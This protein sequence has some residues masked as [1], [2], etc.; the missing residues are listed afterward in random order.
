M[1]RLSFFAAFVA[2]FFAAAIAAAASVP[3][4]VNFANTQAV[5]DM[6]GALKSYHAPSG[7]EADG[8]QWYMTAIVNDSVRPATR[9][10]LAGEPP[11]TALKFFPLATRPEIEQVASSDS[12]VVVEQARAYGHRAYRVTVPPATS[13]SLA[14]RV[15]HATAPPSLLAWTE[16]ALIE[17]NRQIA[18]FIAAVAGLIGASAA[19]MLGLWAMTSHA[20]PRWAAFTLIAL[21]LAR[22][23]TTGMFDAAWIGAF[24]GPYG[25]TAFFSGLALAAGI[26]LADVVTPISGLWLS[27]DR[28]LRWLLLGI[29]ALS[30]LALVGIPGMTIFVDCLVVVGAA[31]IATY[32]VHRGRLGAQAARVLAPTAAVFALVA[33][34]AAYVTLG[35]I[36]DNIMAPA[37]IGGFAA[38]GAVLLALA[39]AAG[40]GIA[41]T[42]PF[43]AR[44]AGIASQT[45]ARASVSSAKSIAQPADNSP[46]ARAALQAIGASHQGVF[47]FDFRSALVRLSPEAA[48]LIGMKSGA[49]DIAQDNWIARIH[50]DDREIYKQA[51]A[52]Y[53]THPGLAFRIEFRVR[54]ESGRYPWFELRATMIGEGATASRCLG[55]MADVT[56]RKESEAAVADRSTR[57]PL[58]GLGNR[59]ALMEALEQLGDRLENAVF[60]VL[61]IDRFKAIHASLGDAGADAVLA[62]I[63]QRL[64]KRFGALAEAFRVGG[65]A[66][67]VLF[68]RSEGG[69]EAIGS[70]LADICTQP[71]PSAGRNV[72]AR[73]SV[74]VAGGGGARDPLDLVKNAELALVQ[75]KRHGGGCA[76]VYST[77]LETT[78]A[79]DP[80]ALETELRRALAEQQLDIFYQPIVRLADGTVAG[81]EALLRWHHPSRGLV[82]PNEFIAHSEQTGLIVALGKFALDRAVRDLAQWQRYF[83]LSP[84]LFGSVN[85]SRRQLR[86]PDF[87]RQLRR[88]LTES[89]IAPG[90]LRLEVTESAV[91]ADGETQQ[92]LHEIAELG[93]A[94]AI[95]DFGAGLS[96]L[97]QLKDLPFD[98]VKIDKS[99]LDGNASSQAGGNSAVVSSIVSLAHELQRTVVAEGVETQTDAAWLK[100]IGCDFA[101][102]FYFSEP[103]PAA[104]VLKFIARYGRIPLSNSSA[105]PSEDASGAAGL[106]G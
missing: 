38:A 33:A 99:F 51:L 20:A 96:N 94:L 97:S 27:A 88:L 19:I 70:E 86:D 29:V 85:L 71:F 11:Q 92:A 93:A 90:T 82:Q 18:I 105:V 89:G 83:P 57:D 40:E 6:Q 61:D 56:S 17:H 87:K 64:T 16:P 65:D 106:S 25:L 91:A 2:V 31:G 5:V 26:K 7:P 95:D 50:P 32:L 22:L 74:G 12:G 69:D 34:A 45:E 9:I 15:Q 100:E 63:A 78:D 21:L 30:L 47:D 54:S 103:M 66:F 102:G 76:R 41:V 67:A 72:F 77:D 52:D 23:S 44:M 79:A 46:I 81:F 43:K 58:T 101:Q 28:W 10:L 4:S 68:P 62:G 48:A 24:G 8:S 37:A 80:V 98:V 53:R 60:A 1:N 3:P 59:V 73:A 84:P 39:I 104:D 49:Q 35:G 55:L 36:S 13:V 75:A 14:M 42:P